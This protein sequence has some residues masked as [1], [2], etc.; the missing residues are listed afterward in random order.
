MSKDN[1]LT[2]TA[3]T[4]TAGDISDYDATAQWQQPAPTGTEEW[5]TIDRGAPLKFTF[6]KIGDHLVGVYEGMEQITNPNNGD[7]FDQA[8]FTDDEGDLVA[9]SPGYQLKVTLATITPGTRVRITY[10]ADVDTGQASPMK[11]F[12]VEKAKS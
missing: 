10:R 4:A 2:A 1:T 7:I 8:L 12:T 9:I 6:D 3:D 5:E 11:S